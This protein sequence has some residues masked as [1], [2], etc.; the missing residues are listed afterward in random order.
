LHVFNIRVPLQEAS[1]DEEYNLSGYAGY[2]LSQH[3]IPCITMK[4]LSSTRYFE[5]PLP[6]TKLFNNPTLTKSKSS[7][8]KNFSKFGAPF[9]PTDQMSQG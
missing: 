1:D 4:A 3:F 7:V 5:R 8:L 9:Y 6:N 2:S